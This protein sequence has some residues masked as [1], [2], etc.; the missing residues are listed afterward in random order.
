MSALGQHGIYGGLDE[1]DSHNIEIMKRAIFTRMLEHRD[2]SKVEK[3]NSDK[4]LPSPI[5]INQ[6]VAP[7]D[8]PVH[9]ITRINAI[10]KGDIRGKDMGNNIEDVTEQFGGL[11]IYKDED[12]PSVKVGPGQVLYN[13]DTKTYVVYTP[14]MSK[15]TVYS[16]DKMK[17]FVSAA[18]GVPNEV[19]SKNYDIHPGANQPKKSEKKTKIPGF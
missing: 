2:S 13:R 11:P 12:D 9:P 19:S 1:K 17:D 3:K 14:D 4:T 6:Q 16:A 15:S 7:E 10:G 5:I 18:T 8:K